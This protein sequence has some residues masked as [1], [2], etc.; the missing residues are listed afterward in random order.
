MI[1]LIAERLLSFI[2]IFLTTLVLFG[3]SLIPSKSKDEQW[4]WKD[5][6]KLAIFVAIVVNI[7]SVLY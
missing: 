3:D 7:W 1:Y 2:L 4:N 5:V 6:L